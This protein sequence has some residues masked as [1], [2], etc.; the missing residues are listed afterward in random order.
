MN[1]QR[2]AMKINVMCQLGHSLAKLSQATERHVGAVIFD[3]K[4]MRVHG[5]GYNGPAAGEDPAPARGDEDHSGDTHAEVNALVKTNAPWL[6]PRSQI[7]YV[8]CA[9]CETCARYI[10]NFGAIGMVIYGADEYD[11][12]ERGLQVLGRAKIRAPRETVIT[13]AANAPEE[14]HYA[15]S[16]LAKALRVLEGLV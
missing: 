6:A 10:I 15:K 1:I 3:P 11:K 2:M 12:F 4:L 14:Q 5:M 9:P 13:N 8:T 16:H 7:M